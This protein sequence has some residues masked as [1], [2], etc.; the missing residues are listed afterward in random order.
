MF[1]HDTVRNGMV[2]SLYRSFSAPLMEGKNMIR[3]TIA[4]CAAAVT[5]S[6]AAT[7]AAHAESIGVSTTVAF[8][9][10]YIFRGVQFA[11]TS[12]QPG[13]ELSYGNFYGGAW[14]NLPVG[15]DDLVVTPGAKNWIYTPA[16][17]LTLMKPFRWILG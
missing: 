3:K 1:R 13:I 5:A 10:R 7:T 6:A 15:D 4:L 9:S 17:V 16:M 11:E 12:F 14:L 2:I 8:E